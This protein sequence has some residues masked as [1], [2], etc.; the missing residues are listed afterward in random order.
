MVQETILKLL[1]EIKLFCVAVY[2]NNYID[3]KNVINSQHKQ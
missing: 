3:I 2:F 1:R